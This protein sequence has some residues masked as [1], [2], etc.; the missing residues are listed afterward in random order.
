[1]FVVVPCYNE[2]KRLRPERLVQWASHANASLV[3]VDDGSTDAT[4]DRI[5]RFTGTHVHLLR[6]PENRGKGE[7][8][9]AGMLFALEQGADYV[10]FLDADLATAPEQ[11]GR[12]RSLLAEHPE[13]D[14]VIG[15][16]VQLA[17]NRIERHPLRH[18]GG[19][20][21]AYLAAAV[22]RLGIYDTQCG[23]KLWRVRDWTPQLF[24]APFSTRWLFD[25]ELFARWTGLR[26]R[27]QRALILEVAL[28]SWSD[29]SGSK[30]TLSD[31]LYVPVGLL[32]IWRRYRR[33]LGTKKQALALSQKNPTQM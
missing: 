16:R 15:S 26:G 8:V 28:P 31:M 6:L 32:K 9:R 21:A 30:I 4:A 14:L 5:E 19:R 7:A 2:S 25:V 22:L 17:G 29:V 33:E 24:D 13:L 18:L 20:L 27:R 11:L 23:A 3:F 1:V 10:G 12:F